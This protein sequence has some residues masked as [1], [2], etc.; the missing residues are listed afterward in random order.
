M[1]EDRSIL[2][3]DDENELAEALKDLLSLD[4]TGVE[5]V[6]SAPAALSLVEKYNYSLILSDYK[7]PGLSGL[8]LAIRL[9]G[10][11]NLTT[12]I[13]M[14]GYCDKEMCLN[15]LR[16]GIQDI[17]EKPIATED[18]SKYIHRAVDIERRKK[19]IYANEEDSSSSHR[20]L[21]LLYATDK[22]LKRSLSSN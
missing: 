21:G 20:M 19:E 18:L 12:L 22:R 4:F 11:G 13:W 5:Y 1:K 14:S 3:I 10:Q 16:L 7:M 6:D 17:I 2:I 9:R 15:G 8:D